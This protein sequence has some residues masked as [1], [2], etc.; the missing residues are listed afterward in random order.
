MVLQLIQVGMQVAGAHE[1]P[2]TIM[3][4]SAIIIEDE[5]STSDR[6]SSPIS[7]AGLRDTL[8]Y[9]N[10][11]SPT[12]DPSQGSNRLLNSN[13]LQMPALSASNQNRRNSWMFESLWS[14]SKDVQHLQNI[15]TA[16]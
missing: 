6:S 13:D 10:P 4:H 11:R 2:W 15:A 1:E 16:G 5:E 12:R 3:A 9:G 8:S 7:R 14:S